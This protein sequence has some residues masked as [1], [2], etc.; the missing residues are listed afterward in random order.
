ME[1][2]SFTVSLL[3][4]SILSTHIPLIVVVGH[5]NITFIELLHDMCQGL[6]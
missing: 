4:S 5:C 1:V 2:N 3:L 6:P